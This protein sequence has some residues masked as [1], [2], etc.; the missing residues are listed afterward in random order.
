M[1]ANSTLLAVVFDSKNQARSVPSQLWIL[2]FIG[3]CFQR[4]AANG[5]ACS[6]FD[7]L[8]WTQESFFAVC[9]AVLCSRHT[10]AENLSITYKPS[11][12]SSDVFSVLPH[13]AVLREAAIVYLIPQRLL[14]YKLH[15]LTAQVRSGGKRNRHASVPS[16]LRL[17]NQ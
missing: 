15:A 14:E 3:S 16:Y 6:A 13:Y 10:K 12:L 8:T 2:A 1:S 17:C 5:N 9:F 7:S 4:M 11:A